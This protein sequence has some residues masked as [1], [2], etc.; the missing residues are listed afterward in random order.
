MSPRPVL[1]IDG[2]PGGWMVAELAESISF[3]FTTS[4]A[5]AVARL[6]DDVAVVAVD[7]PIGLSSN[8]N[9]PA[10][11]LARDRLGPRRSTFFPTPIRSMLEFDDY[12]DANAHGK[13]TVGTGLSKQAWNLL[14]KIREIDALWSPALAD[15]LVEAHPETSFAELAGSPVM[16]KKSTAEGRAKRL[17]LLRRALPSADDALAEVNKSLHVDAVDAAIAAWT[18]RR[19]ANGSAVVLGGE[20]DE[21]GR[22]M[23]LSI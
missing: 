7:M 16:T 5:Q 12:A 20:L 13:E 1:G 9:R 4:L 11:R 14:P 15:R 18:A 23:R 19:V 8:G 3:S 6:D 21:A 10:D 2:A 22:P 17:D